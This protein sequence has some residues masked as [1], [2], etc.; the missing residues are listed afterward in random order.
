MS[1]EQNESAYR[2]LVSFSGLYPTMPEEH[3]FVHGYEAGAIFAEMKRPDTLA[4]ERTVHA[5]N[6]EVLR[7]MCA[8]E[9]WAVEFQ[10]TEP[11]VEPYLSAT[12]KRLPRKGHLSIVAGGQP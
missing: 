11:P 4:L 7:R 5:R 8:A 6:V 3:A 9:G 12:F 2:L 10:S 1:D